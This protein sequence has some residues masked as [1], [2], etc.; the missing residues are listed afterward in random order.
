MFESS[1]FSQ[2][3]RR[4]DA[5]GAARGGDTQR[6]YQ[7]PSVRNKPGRDVRRNLFI[8]EAEE[9]A[10]KDRCEAECE[11]ARSACE[12]EPLRKQ[13]PYHPPAARAPATAEWRSR[14]GARARARFEA[15]RRSR[16]RA[17]ESAPPQMRQRREAQ[18]AQP[19]PRTGPLCQRARCGRSVAAR[20]SQTAREQ[21]RRQPVMVNGG[22]S[23]PAVAR[24]RACS[25]STSAPHTGCARGTAGGCCP[26]WLR[27]LR[28]TA[29]HDGIRGTRFR[30]TG[31]ASDERAASFI[32]LPDGP[33]DSRGYVTSGRR[34][35]A[36]GRPP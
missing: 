14:A 3:C 2:G 4:V 35:L 21:V 32:P 5:T 17:Q 13:L 31:C 26:P 11:R 22:S 28:R 9:Q 7:D 23:R 12:H 24:G 1:A 16:T 10:R 27:P 15:C 30:G 33:P 18:I 8:H 20:H 25:R 36:P 6:E 34:A 19:L 29:R